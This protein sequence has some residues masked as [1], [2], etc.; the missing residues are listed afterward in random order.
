[1][2]LIWLLSDTTISV[3]IET[4]TQ[5]PYTNYLYGFTWLLMCETSAVYPK[6]WFA[7]N[8][9]SYGKKKHIFLHYKINFDT[10]VLMVGLYH[11]LM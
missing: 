8:K 7:F 6:Q 10:S 1:M 3:S 9:T 4:M 2:Q 11:G 5:T